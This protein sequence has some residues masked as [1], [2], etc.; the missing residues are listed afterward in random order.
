MKSIGTIL[1]YEDALI[2]KHS[3]EHFD[4]RIYLFCLSIQSILLCKYVALF[5]EATHMN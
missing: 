5:F 3:P 1:K 4:E 2:L